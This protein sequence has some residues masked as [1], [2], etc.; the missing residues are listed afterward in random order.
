MSYLYRTKSGQEAGPVSRDTLAQLL[1]AGEITPATLVRP[2]GST[3]WKTYRETNLGP[4][5]ASTELASAIKSWRPSRTHYRIGAVVAGLIAAFLLVPPLYDAALN[6]TPSPD[7]IAADAKSDYRL[8][9]DYARRAFTV[10]SVTPTFVTTGERAEGKATV[11]LKYSDAFYSADDPRQRLA[12]KGDDAAAFAAALEKRAALP[13]KLQPTIPPP[14]AGSFFAPAKPALSTFPIEVTFA[15]A[16]ETRGWSW[17]HCLGAWSPLTRGWHAENISWSPAPGELAALKTR[18]ELPPGALLVGEESGDR[19]LANLVARRR[20]FVTA[21]N[22]AVI[23]LQWDQLES[24]ALR[25]VAEDFARRAKSPRVFAVKS[26]YL[27]RT[28]SLPQPGE[29]AALGATAVID[30]TEDLYQVAAEQPAQWAEFQ[31]GSPFKTAQEWVAKKQV[32]IDSPERPDAVIYDLVAP[33]TRTAS[34]QLEVQRPAGPLEVR[35]VRWNDEAVLAAL[36]PGVTADQAARTAVFSSGRPPQPTVA[37]YHAAL[38]DYVATVTKMRMHQQALAKRYAGVWRGTM[39]NTA[40]D[41]GSGG[42]SAG[43]FSL[44]VRNDLRSAVYVYEEGQV[45]LDLVV[46]IDGDELVMDAADARKI[47]LRMRARES[48][49]AEISSRI[50]RANGQWAE[51]RGTFEAVPIPSA[52]PWTLPATDGTSHTNEMYLGKPLVLFLMFTTDID[53]YFNSPMRNSIKQV[54]KSEPEF[55]RANINLRL[56]EVIYGNETAD[57]QLARVKAA[58]PKYGMP[59]TILVQDTTHRLPHSYDGMPCALVLDAEGRLLGTFV[60]AS[61]MSGLFEKAKALIDQRSR[62]YSQ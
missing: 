36:P 8:P 58:I 25:A 31:S 27:E 37:A 39:I 12:E 6:R 5:D 48:A 24:A 7:R 51:A 33:L 15:Y 29:T 9:H 49:V 50:D 14:I 23:A 40:N 38:S 2:I 3:E 62:L 22:E 13:A 19:A 60:G 42:D 35:S 45:V 57:S 32:R 28:S 10:I 17:R 52:L 1:L 47:R 41:R 53:S 4:I 34:L 20:A 54:S 56:V 59:D 61:K 11:T 26:L 30:Q 43:T 21:V 46:R 55:A 18:A 16:K 44:S